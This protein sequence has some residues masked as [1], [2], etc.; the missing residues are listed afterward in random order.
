MVSGE[1]LVRPLNEQGV[2]T[3]LGILRCSGASICTPFCRDRDI[4]TIGITHQ[5]GAAFMVGG[6]GE[7][8]GMVSLFIIT[9]RPDVAKAVTGW[10]ETV[11]GAFERVLLSHMALRC[12]MVGSE[13]GAYD[14]DVATDCP[15]QEATHYGFLGGGYLQSYREGFAQLKTSRPKSFHHSSLVEVLKG[16]GVILPPDLRGKKLDSG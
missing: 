13:T 5:G 15:L 2:G 1:M 8:A 7:P 12:K 14:M 16:S 6:Y 11:H 3:I 4:H 10:G 9:A